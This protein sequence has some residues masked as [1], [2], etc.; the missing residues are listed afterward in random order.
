[1]AFDF[2]D[3][4]QTGE[5]DLYATRGDTWIFTVDL[6]DREVQEG[7]TLTFTLAAEVGGDAIITQT[8]AADQSFYIDSEQTQID[9]GS[10]YY[11]VQLNTAN[12]ET[13]TVITPAVFEVTGEVTK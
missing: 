3:N 12:G 8:I 4:Q 7:D 1:M 2:R 10:Y 9:V 11:D 5:F 13:F 6:V